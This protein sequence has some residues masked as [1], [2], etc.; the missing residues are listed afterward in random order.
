MIKRK[1]K[2]KRKQLM[3]RQANT[4]R[5]EETNE[6]D[7]NGTTL[8]VSAT[9]NTISDSDA[10]NNDIDMKAVDET[11]PVME[12]ININDIIE[13]VDTLSYRICETIQHFKYYVTTDWKN[14][15]CRKGVMRNKWKYNKNT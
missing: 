2:I 6:I 9:Q 1:K 4:A 3:E 11:L 8:S 5:A 13:E 10:N 7:H 15:F 12:T 14:E